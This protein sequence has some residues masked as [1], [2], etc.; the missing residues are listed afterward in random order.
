[1]LDRK[2]YDQFRVAPT[3]PA[4][5][6]NR[7]V[8]Q[9]AKKLADASGGRLKVEKFDESNEPKKNAFQLFVPAWTAAA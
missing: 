8:E 9:I 1:M 4:Q 5:L 2:E 6:R 7:D 3:D